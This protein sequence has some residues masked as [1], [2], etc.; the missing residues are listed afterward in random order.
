MTLEP[1]AVARC[2]GWPILCNLPLLGILVLFAFAPPASAEG[3]TGTLRQGGEVRVDPKTNRITVQRHGVRT[4]LWDGV[5]RL[6]DGSSITVRSG[7]VVPNVEILEARRGGLATE[8]AWAG[9]VIVGQ[10]P[11]EA[12]VERVCGS[13]GDCAHRP[14]CPPA[15]QLLE[16]ERQERLAS[17]APDRT[18][19]TSH[20]CQQAETDQLFASCSGEAPAPVASA[21]DLVCHRLVQKVCGQGG[22]C[23]ST[24]ACSA[25]QQLSDMSNDATSAAGRAELHYQCNE[26]LAD[27]AF[28]QP[29]T[30]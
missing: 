24:T 14:G 27:E 25:A 28:F 30:P 19:Y 18:T 1:A 12:L 16:M 4:Q 7:Q 17:D 10:S 22:A 13:Q 29:C 21:T 8:E 20:Q 23:A 2:N 11:C 26:A 3:W 15:R 6:Q 5:H 9:E